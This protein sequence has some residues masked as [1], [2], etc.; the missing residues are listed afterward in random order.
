MN[1]VVIGIDVGTGSARAAVFNARGRRLGRGAADT[2]L[3]RL[4]GDRVEQSSADIWSSVVAAVRAA[5]TDAGVAPSDV[6]GI[7]F[8]ATCSL[9][10][11]DREEEP[12]PLSK[13]E[14]THDVI[15][16]M[17][18]RGVAEAAEMTESG[19]PALDQVGGV[20]SPEMQ[21]PKLLWLKRHAPE[22]WSQLGKARDLSD[23]LTWRATGNDARSSCTTV[24]KWCLDYQRWVASPQTGWPESLLGTVDMADL[25]AEDHAIVGRDILVPGTPIGSGLSAKAAD[26]L[27]LAPGTAVAASAIDAH[28]GAVGIVASGAKGGSTLGRLAMIMGTSNCHLVEAADRLAV[29]GVWGPYFGAL[30]GSAWLAEAGQSAAGALL[31]HLIVSHPACEGD[32]N[33]EHARLDRELADLL[34]DSDADTF[35]GDRLIAPDFLGN[36]SPLA[37]P[38][39]SG[40]ILGLG[41]DSDRRDLARTYLAGLFALAYGTRHIVEVL[42][43]N[44]HRIDA[45]VATGSGAKN[46]LLMKAHADATGL[47]VDLPSESEGVLLGSAMLAAT[48]ARMHPSLADAMAAMSADAERIEPDPS[49]RPMHDRRYA[50]TRLMQRFLREGRR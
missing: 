6:V 2:Q 33:A 36:R 31:D 41:L 45:I 25:L 34:S 9:V 17:D 50:R 8:D 22:I 4:S 13:G 48:A 38:E 26:E 14:P 20:M 46:R 35:L 24:C 23:W 43:E 37:D 11:S 18:H 44:G 10:L 7:G 3:W 16:W 27:G 21:L 5:V 49:A 39:M 32:A 30:S 42:E 15:V 1:P 19:D 12:L 47:P 28:A 40:A 29:P